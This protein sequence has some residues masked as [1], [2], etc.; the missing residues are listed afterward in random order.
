[1]LNREKHQLIMGNILRDIYTD[2]SISSLLGFKGGT[3]AYFF[4]ALPRFSVD[5]DFDLLVVSEENQKLVFE[6]IVNILAKYGQ[7][8]NQYIKRFTVF[9]L[10]SYGEDDHN[11]KVEVNVRKLLE[12]IEEC[13]EMKEYLGIS[14]LVA[15]KDYLFA[16]KLS[17]L[18][19]R[20][21]V[22]MRDIYDICYFAKN[23]W[24]INVEMVKERTGKTVKEYLADCI[25]FIEKVKD[26]QMMQG[27]GELV[28]SEKE[29]AWIREHLKNDT[30]FML[31]NYMSVL[32]Y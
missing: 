25:D 4:Y 13:Y 12:N 23:N 17:A 31:R 28:D 20:K 7:V 5:L 2:I 18:T 15:K 1:M 24:D 26:N 16:S 21:E 19:S 22:A 11:I 29:K 14:M 3:C 32:R 8:K 6:R 9:A 30:M 27:L 10:L